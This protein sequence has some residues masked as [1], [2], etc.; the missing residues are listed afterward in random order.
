MQKAAMAHNTAEYSL[1]YKQNN[2]MLCR[3]SRSDAHSSNP[4]K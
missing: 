4:G 2:G 1:P 3:I